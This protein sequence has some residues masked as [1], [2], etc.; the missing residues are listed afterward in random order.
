M[1]RGAPRNLDRLTPEDKSLTFALADL[2][3]LG[4]AHPGALEITGDT[5]R[6]HHALAAK[7]DSKAAEAIGLPPLVDLVF[8]TDV[9][10]ALGTPSFRIYH[11]WVKNGRKQLPSRVGAILNRESPNTTA[12]RLFSWTK[13]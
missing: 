2:R 12:S 6:M 4:D 10:G 5:I 1:T 11:E 13:K 8:R 9:E 3:A 7:L